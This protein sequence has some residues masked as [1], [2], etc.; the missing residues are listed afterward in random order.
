M[1]RFGPSNGM[2][3]KLRV[4]WYRVAVAHPKLL[5]ALG[6][7][8]LA[9]GAL[10]L[11]GALPA[12][13]IPG[14]TA[15]GTGTVISAA[16]SL[17]NPP[18][19]QPQGVAVAN[20]ITY[21]SNGAGHSIDLYDASG[22]FVSAIALSSVAVPS[23]YPL[24]M[25]VSSDG[26]HLYVADDN[27]DGSVFD[28]ST[29]TN[30][31]AHTFPVVGQPIAIALSPDDATFYVVSNSD[32]LVYAYATSDGSALGHSVSDGLYETAFHVMV[33]ADGSKIYETMRDPVPVPPNTTG[34]LRILRAS[35]LGEIGHVDLP[36]ASGLAQ[37]PDGSRI[38]VGSTDTAFQSVIAE[39]SPDG[40]AT[41]RDV[42]VQSDPEQFIVS[43]DGKWIYAVSRST[44]LLDVVDTTAFTA[45]FT[46]LS[47]GDPDQLALSADGLRLYSTNG[48]GEEVKVLSI[49]KLT[50]TSPA[51]VTPGTGAT[52]FS[53]QI[54]DG[55]SPIA[56]Y[57]TNTVTFDIL[58]SSNAVVATGTASPDASGAA[59]ASID[60]SSLPVGTYS[61]RAT[62]DPIAGTVVVTATGFRVSDSAGLAATGID[63]TLPTILGIALLGTGATLVTVRR[64]AARRGA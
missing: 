54:T 22:A 13:A 26:S 59:S 7:I 15:S 40:T 58:N 49:A 39:F 62:L 11:T 17:V 9:S 19:N 37:S 5:R 3:T 53:A 2:F 63:A 33:S 50:L 34:G 36:N 55:T 16:P 10:L 25:V 47:A 45:D 1:G 60:L 6:V 23:P 46:G 56:D 32:S 27:T 8:S 21:V 35:D 42:A 52:T 41:G 28:I 24:A 12:A 29:A 38:W 48:A 61:V 64:R 18:A 30:T 57:T 51:A 14:L 44:G 43:A 4:D 31:L 20:G